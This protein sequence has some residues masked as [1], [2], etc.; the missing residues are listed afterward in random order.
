MVVDF[1]FGTQIKSSYQKQVSE[2]VNLI[3]GM[4]SSNVSGYLW[5]VT[6]N[7]IVEV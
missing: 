3:K 6:L 4:G 7:K 1:K 2:Y 5:Y